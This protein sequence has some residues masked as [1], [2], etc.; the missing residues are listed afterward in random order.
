M[1]VDNIKIDGIF[2]RDIHIDPINKLFVESIH[3]ISEIMG[4]KTTAEYV[5]NQEIL[6]CIKSIGIDY[7]QGYFFSKPAPIKTLL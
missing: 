4:I 2:I 3:N 7:A 1:P 5:E 6:N